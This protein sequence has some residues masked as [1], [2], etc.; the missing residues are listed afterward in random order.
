MTGRPQPTSHS[1]PFH[2]PLTPFG[3]LRIKCLTRAH[4][5][6]SPRLRFLRGI[7][8]PCLHGVSLTY[9]ECPCLLAFV[10]SGLAFITDSNTCGATIHGYRNLK[11]SQGVSTFYAPGLH[12]SGAMRHCK[13]RI[14]PSMSNALSL[15]DHALASLSAY[16]RREQYQS[17]IWS[18]G[19]QD[20]TLEC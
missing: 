12:D 15:S 10:G 19:V 8:C 13:V 3:G 5:K 16:Y 14:I 4:S 18:E 9:Q 17:A 2:L 11:T 20:R 6:Q 1:N 7:A